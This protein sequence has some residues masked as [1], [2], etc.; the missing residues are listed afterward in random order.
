MLN[1]K[2]RYTWPTGNAYPNEAWR[3]LR[4]SRQNVVIQNVE[5]FRATV[6]PLTI[7]PLGE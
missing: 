1:T 7:A 4:Q 6:S 5:G 3:I 2:I